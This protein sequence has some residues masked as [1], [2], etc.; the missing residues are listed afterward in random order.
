MANA[1]PFNSISRDRVYKAEDWA[2]YFATFLGNGVFPKPATGLQVIINSGMKIRVKV[3]FAFVNGYAFRN[4][5]DYD[6][7]LKTADGSLARI[8]RIVMRWDLIKRDMYID[9]LQGAYA[10]SPVARGI[11]RNAEIYE[12]A[13]AD[14]YVRKGT[15]S[16]LTTDI[17]DQRFNTALCGVVKGTIEEINTTAFMDKLNAHLNNFESSFEAWFVNVKNQLGTD[18][19]G[20][21]Q[22]QIDAIVTITA[23]EIDAVIGA[24]GNIVIPELPIGEFSGDRIT[25]ADIGSL[26]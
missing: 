20:N 26:F 11:T 15:T 7:T 12:L 16:I 4:A 13:L 3:G 5:T 1:L 18:V 21:L 25:E 19:A 6:I 2:W 14:V 24:T 10:A 9:I 22:N 23:A 8:D 17:T